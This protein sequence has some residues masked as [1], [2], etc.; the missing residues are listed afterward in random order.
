M[1]KALENLALTIDILA[2]AIFA[3]KPDE[4]TFV[5]AFGWNA[6]AINS[7]QAAKLVSQFL[8]LIRNAGLENLTKEQEQSIALCQSSITAFQNSTLPYFYNGNIAG[9]YPSYLALVENIRSVIDQTLGWQTVPKA[10]AIP[11]SLARKLESIEIS[12]DKIV[13]DETALT[14]KMTLISEASETAEALPIT[15]KQLNDTKT[16]LER[17]SGVA[18]EF[19]GK[20]DSLHQQSEATLAEIR[21]HASEAASLAKQS[22]EAYAATTSVGLGGAFDTEAKSLAASIRWW[23]GGLF[24]ALCAGAGV[25]YIRFP[26]LSDALSRS[27]SEPVIIIV[28]LTI[29]I[30]SLGLPLWFAGI[31]TKQIQE[32]FKI[33]QDYAFKA[34]VAKA[35]EG[36][37]REANRFDGAIEERLFLAALQRLEQEPLRFVDPKTYASPY[38]E[39]GVVSAVQDTALEFKAVAIKAV[40]DKVGLGKTEGE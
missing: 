1:N 5:A 20:I 34:N 32:R 26:Q 40:K 35:Y 31:A 30:L 11:A 21:Q 28:E 15:L 12:I 3:G 38:H 14:S 16:S 10:N 24:L 19:I 8:P 22:S 9:A 7:S 39:T 33:S 25:G 2:K 37:R 23:V 29:S 6:P 18:S 4:I 13:V 36:Y 17:S 27:K